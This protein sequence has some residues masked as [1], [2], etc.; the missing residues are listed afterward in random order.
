M[1]EKLSHYAKNQL[2][3]GK[4]WEPDLDV[5]AVLGNLKPNND[6]CESILGLNDYLT[7]AIPN[8]HQMTRS[9]LVKVK[10]NGTMKWYQDL[11]QEQRSTVTKLAVARRRDV[12]KQYCEEE[13]ARSKQRQDR[14][15][16]C[17]LKRTAMREKA[18][19]EKDLLSQQHIITTTA[20]LEEA[21][22]EVDA[23]E[24]TTAKKREK[25]LALLRTQIKIRKKIHQDSLFSEREKTTTCKHCKGACRVYCCKPV[26]TTFTAKRTVRF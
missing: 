7:T 12:L 1:N 8:M 16:Q 19:K 17:H 5:Q 21:L 4:Y 24:A 10:K 9:N 11:P 13:K 18:A 23:C 3:G 15:K 14:M 25:K 22:E 2:P 20:E 6:V 26:P